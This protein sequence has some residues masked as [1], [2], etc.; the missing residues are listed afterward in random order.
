MRKPT[1]QR[2]EEIVRSALNLAADNSVKK[3]TS[4]AIA[5]RVGIAQPTIF[6]HFKTLDAIFVAAIE[7]VAGGLFKSL[8]ESLRADK[9]ADIRLQCLLERQLDHISRHP[10]IPRLLFSERLQAESP[11]LKTVAQKVMVEYSSML[12]RLLAEGVESGCFHKDVD[13]EVT[14]RMV[15]ATV[16]GLVLRWSL[17]DFSYDLKAEIEPLVLFLNGVLGSKRKQ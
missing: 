2:R 1:A 7:W 13:P 4:Q 5:E 16:Q 8:E 17:H 10:G 11:L 14:A 3:I 15:T 9:P 6:R 12:A